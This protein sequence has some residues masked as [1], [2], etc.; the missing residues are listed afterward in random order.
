[1]EG[2]KCLLQLSHTLDFEGTKDRELRYGFPTKD[3]QF[4][5]SVSVQKED[6]LY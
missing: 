1:M 4:L 2:W 3:V 5:P 6:P